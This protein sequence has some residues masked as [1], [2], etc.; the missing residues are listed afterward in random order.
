M[1][2]FFKQWR[3]IEAS[4]RYLNY[5]LVPYYFRI[6]KTAFFRNFLIKKQFKKYGI[7]SVSLETT[8]FCNRKCEFCFYHERFPKRDLGMMELTTYKKIIDELVQINFCGTVYP[9][10]YGEPL[11]DKRLPELIEYTRKKLPN[12]FIY[13]LTNGDFLNEELFK[14]LIYKGVDLFLIT[15]YNDK[16]K[17]IF[18]Y[19]K[20]KCPFHFTFR[21]YKDFPKV[22]RAGQIFKRNIQL[23][24]PCLRPSSQIVINWKGDVILCC[25]DFYGENV[26]GNVNDSNLLSIW[27][28]GTSAYYRNR[29]LVGQRSTIPI[30]KCCD[31]EGK[32]AW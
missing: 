27:N 8:S 13:V 9:H 22:D 24:T 7:A 10:V 32:I 3:N 31:M 25:N 28:N 16:D 26:M 30:C 18:N 19:L 4:R 5:P 23:N 6:V 21:N 15:N 11:M 14:H 1:I 29:L 20:E 2:E 12:C 17:E